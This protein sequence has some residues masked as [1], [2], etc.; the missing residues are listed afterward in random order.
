M[1]QQP[2]NI[3]M[4]NITIFI[5]TLLL[6]SLSFSQNTYSPNTRV[7]IEAWTGDTISDFLF[8]NS[9]EVYFYK[10]GTVKFNSTTKTLGRAANSHHK[11]KIKLV[12][13]HLY[14]RTFDYYT[15]EDETTGED[16]TI[17]YVVL[18]RMDEN[19]NTMTY[20]FIPD[21]HSEWIIS[22]TNGQIRY[23]N[24]NGTICNADGNK[25]WYGPIT[26]IFG[27]SF[28]KAKKG[29]PMFLQGNRH[30]F[31]TEDNH[32]AYFYY[33][34]NPNG[35]TFKV[36]SETNFPIQ[37]NSKISV[38]PSPTFQTRFVHENGDL[39]NAGENSPTS[40]WLGPLATGSNK[41][42]EKTEIN[43]EIPGTI[44]YTSEDKELL[45]LEWFS[46]IGWIN[47]NFEIPN[48]NTLVSYGFDNNELIVGYNHL[49][50][51][52]WRASDFDLCTSCKL[53]SNETSWDLL[54]VFPNPT[55]GEVEIMAEDIGQIEVL[56]SIGEIIGNS[57]KGVWD[58]S[59][60][61]P[62]I[63]FIKITKTNG[64]LETVR[65]IR[66]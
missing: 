17:S 16:V 28:P 50:N 12:N 38:S 46:G 25:Q 48:E 19:G 31:V 52:H 65:V 47:N 3:I 44:L 18:H 61:R 55:Q 27:N 30:Y 29:T 59:S 37:N 51:D 62:G 36:Y 26:D 23:I 11:Q 63:Y 53:G 40:I 64:D 57:E 1:S 8:N 49:S 7:L 22:P 33:N 35:W 6:S 20:D 45:K 24:S 66:E 54:N 41:P 39:Y 2:K 10:S 9:N 42:H 32:L 43:S 21:N 56:N 15:Y 5:I 4:K 34:F 13:N 60:S 58:F 14:Y